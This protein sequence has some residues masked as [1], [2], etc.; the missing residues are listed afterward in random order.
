MRIEK[1]MRFKGNIN[2]VCFEVLEANENIVKYAVILNGSRV[3][4]KVHIFGRKAFEHCN[5]SVI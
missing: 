3:S 1:G 5:I 4:D 2:N